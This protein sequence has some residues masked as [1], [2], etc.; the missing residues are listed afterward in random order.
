SRG[1]FL[2]VRLASGWSILNFNSRD[3]SNGK[4]RRVVGQ[5]RSIHLPIVSGGSHE[6]QCALRHGSWNSPS[7]R[8]W[9]QKQRERE[10]FVRGDQCLLGQERPAMPWHSYEV[11]G[12]PPGQRPRSGH[13]Q[14]I[15]D[16]RSR[17]N[18]PSA[19]P[20]GGDRIHALVRHPSRE[21]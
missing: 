4:A 13:R 20:R 15:A 18:W 2:F 5:K 3:R 9:K 16:G 19:V 6:K 14:R 12:R 8:L 1:P 21:G 10:E 17:E 11:A 7:G